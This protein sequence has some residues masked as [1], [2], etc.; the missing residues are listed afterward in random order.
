MLQLS[1]EL[2]A[3][4]SEQAQDDAEDLEQ[5]VKQL[6]LD[7]AS[8]QSTLG[9]DDALKQLNEANR[10]LEEM[11]KQLDESERE[12]ERLTEEVEGLQN[13]P[14][15][16]EQLRL[17]GELDQAREDNARIGR[18]LAAAEE[19]AE[20]ERERALKLEAELAE[21]ASRLEDMTNSLKLKTQDL[22]EMRAMVQAEQRRAELSDQ[23]KSGDR[24]KLKAKNRELDRLLRENKMLEKANADLRAAKLKCA[25]EVVQ[26][27]EATVSLDARVRTAEETA[28]SFTAA[29]A[30]LERE[31][32]ALKEHASSLEG[33]VEERDALLSS[34]EEQFSTQFAE[35][36]SREGQLSGEIESL[37]QAAAAASAVAEAAGQPVPA[38][39]RPAPG[40]GVVPSSALPAEGSSALASALR[41]A[42]NK[43]VLLLE[44]YEQL[45]KDTKAEIVDALA[46]QDGELNALRADVQRLQDQLQAERQRFVQ[47][48]EAL[49]AAQGDAEEAKSQLGA[50]ESGVYGLSDAMRDIKMLK[51]QLRS[52]EDELSSSVRALNQRGEQMEDLLEENRMLRHRAGLPEEEA[53]DV[54]GFRT[55]AQVELE[56]LRALCKQLE[57][58]VGNLEDERRALK[59]ELRFRA[60]WQGM[61]AARLGLSATQLQLLDEYADSLRHEH[62]GTEEG[63]SLSVAT[64]ERQVQILRDRLRDA[65][66]GT[67][68][69]S[70]RE[71]AARVRELEIS[72]ATATA[73]KGAALEK[74]S[75]AVAERNTYAAENAALR[76]AIANKLASIEAT[77]REAMASGGQAG[78]PSAEPSEAGAESVANELSSVLQALRQGLESRPPPQMALAQ[79]D[80]PAPTQ[81]APTVHTD[82]ALASDVAALRRELQGLR[83]TL[84]ATGS[85]QDA[86]NASGTPLRPAVPESALARALGAGTGGIA[87]GGTAGE[88]SHDAH[89]ANV[90]LVEA[91]TELARREQQLE[92][93]TGEVEAYRASWERVLDQQRLLYAEYVRRRKEW[94]S[95]ETALQ[96]RVRTAEAAQMAAIERAESAQRLADSAVAEGSGS[97]GGGEGTLKKAASDAVQQ[98][99]LAHAKNA[100]LNEALAAAQSSERKAQRALA[101]AK[102]RMESLDESMRKRNEAVE[103]KVASAALQV[104]QLESLLAGMVPKSELQALQDDV[105]A[106]AKQNK[107][108]S[109]ALGELVTNAAAQEGIASD[110]TRLSSALAL[111]QEESAQAQDQVVALRAALASSSGGGGSGQAIASEE[112]VALRMSEAAS[113]R[114]CR[115]LQSEVEASEHKSEKLREQILE[116]EDQVKELS[117]A[118]RTSVEKQ[119]ELEESLDRM[120]PPEE[121]D[122]LR[123][124]LEQVNRTLSLAREEAVMASGSAERPLVTSTGSQ[125]SATTTAMDRIAAADALLRQELEAARASVVR[126]N[127]SARSAEEARRRTQQRLELSMTGSVSISKA[128]A[129]AKGLK[130]MQTHAQKLSK[131]VSELTE[132]VRVAEDARQ[133]AELQLQTSSVRAPASEL[134]PTLSAASMISSESGVLEHGTTRAQ[135]R[136]ELDARL[137]V[138]RM[139]RLL[140]DVRAQLETATAGRATA[141]RGRAE[142]EETA[143]RATIELEMTQAELADAK[144]HR[145]VSTADTP[146]VASGAPP[147][148]GAVVG[149][150][151]SGAAAAAAVP[152]GSPHPVVSGSVPGLSTGQTVSAGAGASAVA[153]EA[154]GGVPQPAVAADAEGSSLETLGQ[155]ERLMKLQG[156]TGA[157][158][159]QLAASEQ[160]RLQLEAQLDQAKDQVLELRSLLTRMEASSAAG[161]TQSAAASA[162]GQDTD[163]AFE[164]VSQVAQ[165]TID[166][167]RA[168]LEEKS[169]QVDEYRN[170]VRTAQERSLEA[171]EADRAELLRLQDELHKAESRHVDEM[172]QALLEPAASRGAA[173]AAA[174]MSEG[175][176]QLVALLGERESQVEVLNGKIEA[177]RLK[178]EA[179]EAE[180]REQLSAKASELEAMRRESELERMRG[181]SRAMENLVQRLKLQLGSKERKLEQLKVAV[182]DLKDKLAK[183]MKRQADVTIGKS[184]EQFSEDTLAQLA[185]AQSQLKTTQRRLADA[186]SASKAAKEAEQRLSVE[187]AQLRSELAEARETARKARAAGSKVRAPSDRPSGAADKTALSV[188]RSRV[189]ELEARVKTLEEANAS[190]QE[191]SSQPEARSAAAVAQWEEGKKAAK[192]IEALRAKL[193]ASRKEAA[194]A[195]EEADRFERTAASLARERDA[196]LLRVGTG[197][198]GSAESKASIRA[199]DAAKLK[200]MEDECRRLE[201]ELAEARSSAASEAAGDSA[202]AAEVEKLRFEL[203]LARRSA[204]GSAAD[205]S[206]A[207]ADGEKERDELRSAII[208]RDMELAEVKVEKEAAETQGASLRTRMDLLFDD[209]T[210]ARAGKAG[211]SAARPSSADNLED[212]V[213]ALKAI[214]EKL[215]AENESLRRG[216][217]SASTYLEAVKA[218]KD[219]RGKNKSLRDELEKAARGREGDKREHANAIAR[220]EERAEGLRK[221]LSE[222]KRAA[223]AAER[224]AAERQKSGDAGRE[225][226]AQLSAAAK[227]AADEAKRLQARCVE[228][229]AERAALKREVAAASA[230]VATADVARELASLKNAHVALAKERDDLRSE[231]SAFTPE[232]FEELEDLKWEHSELNRVVAAYESKYGTI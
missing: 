17:Q 194:E 103:K 132:Q 64:L 61:E 69:E 127:A 42:R 185:H 52:V 20:R 37:R 163:A 231:L 30:E 224:A 91:L 139:G 167:L 99:M 209:A 211:Q 112:L 221:N 146:A 50:Y 33:S 102:S 170:A 119:S 195:K 145:A 193:G 55:A 6:K 77:Q 180:L 199:R 73:E 27:S 153:H 3:A 72:L 151:Q 28:A 210:Q 38:V 182:G 150:V 78:A 133:A 4:L 96:E 201:S 142:A 162:P 174:S 159:R 46:E 196:L 152:T 65:E 213:K 62:K 92:A 108:L 47:L 200:S 190:L 171:Q 131:K 158:A 18:R 122:A 192:R 220:L 23:G 2:S 12:R 84:Q 113:E 109:E 175:Y 204:S 83:E 134:R 156:E 206:Q 136:E 179:S 70:D 25:E 141:E 76:D 36:Q 147:Q 93:M 22:E 149:N 138:R 21:K 130:E 203:D 118:L 81:M 14:T 166:R 35:W 86:G 212:V 110:S 15:N 101:A 41:D 154:F 1:A 9:S 74:L 216:A 40:A 100:K 114:R 160:A 48:D 16:L 178:Y 169:K 197:R 189:S 135:R 58:E 59:V 98:L 32:E 202:R 85:A 148:A 222:A 105:L 97:G 143:L 214:I 229:E 71:N 120:M 125:P 34:F 13:A 8:A 19:E 191:D 87:V 117:T 126:A 53:L 75:A 207:L 63:Q 155:L 90:Q 11:Y 225:E 10:E 124:E 56:Q 88:M 95:D 115:V 208:A 188:A 227:D 44:A 181:P 228:L 215:R 104:S 45:E 219:L 89:L 107:E 173:P 82:P 140:D 67:R 49:A 232:F 39:L 121:A 198:T 218:A 43:E 106:A 31:I 161:H 123:H 129:W 183:E 205:V 157:L 223:K 51:R 128:Q 94:K 177:L 24:N 230:G 57:K 217:A 116:L 7:V 111:A 172:R 164:R 29:R 137:E 176:D 54:T 80:T 66:R 168:A 184:N 226:I 187:I 165:G 5:Q 186:T 79:L 26:L 144:G 60:K 68:D